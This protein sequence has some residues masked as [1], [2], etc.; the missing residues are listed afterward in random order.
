M[1]VAGLHGFAAV[2][3]EVLRVFSQV[4]SF[5]IC[6]RMQFT[7]PA[8]SLR[9]V[10]AR[11]TASFMPPF[12]QR[13]MQT[14]ET[15]ANVERQFWRWNKLKCARSKRD[16]QI[17][18]C[19]CMYLFMYIYIYAHMCTHIQYVYVHLYQKLSN[20]GDCGYARQQTTHTTTW[21]KGWSHGDKKFTMAVGFDRIGVR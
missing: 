6:Y 4:Q 19:N 10:T 20:C 7:S 1:T 18:L 3:W 12:W 17:H 9:P 21:R 16:I 5:P 11:E 8:K 13:S 14:T 15:V 2:V